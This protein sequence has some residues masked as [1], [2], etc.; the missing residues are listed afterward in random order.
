MQRAQPT[1]ASLKIEGA[2]DLSPTTMRKQP[3]PGGGLSVDPPP[4]PQDRT[5]VS[6]HLDFNL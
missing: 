2:R 5:L 1:I 6:Q 3:T 4:E